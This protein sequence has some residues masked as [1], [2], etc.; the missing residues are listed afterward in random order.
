MPKTVAHFP[1]QCA[2]NSGPVINGVINSLTHAGFQIVSDS[3]DADIAII[4]SVLWNG[5]MLGNREVYRHYRNTGRPVICVEVGALHR[6]T[7]W[8]LALNHISAN[9]FYG[10]QQNLDYDRPKKL[11]IVLQTKTNTYNKILVAGQH[12]QS[13]QLEGVDQESWYAQKIQEVAAGR[14]VV[15]RSHPRCSLDSGKFTNV[16]WEQPKKLIN[17]YDNFDI[18][19][20]FDLV[21]N[22][23]SGPG[24]Q[25]VIAGVPVVV[26][27]SSLAYN[28]VDREQWLVEICHTEY[29]VEEINQGNW[30]HR[31]GLV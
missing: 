31:L 9:G 10:H 17:T 2:Q 19:W 28:V 18:H 24:I 29:T 6:G 5:R 3:Y 22:Y 11:G 4:W 8:K 27:S 23:N 25:A 21:I 26:D 15:V 13:L 20:N 12:K 30:I 14:E 1:L 7:T 16:S